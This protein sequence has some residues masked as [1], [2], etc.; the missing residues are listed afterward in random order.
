VAWEE[1]EKDRT[2]IA[3]GK[4]AAETLTGKS[5]VKNKSRGETL[6]TVESQFQVVIP[7]TARIEG[8][9]SSDLP[10]DSPAVYGISIL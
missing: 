4:G 8:L 9:G 10:R 3:A 5:G 1:N 7:V 2:S 6:T